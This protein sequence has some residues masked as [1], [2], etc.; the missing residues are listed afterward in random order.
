MSW[1]ISLRSVRKCAP[2]GLGGGDDGNG[3]ARDRSGT[4][5]HDH[6]HGHSLGSS[7]GG[8]VRPSGTT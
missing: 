2:I 6:Y 4:E 1:V 8:F 5:D 3:R 7:R